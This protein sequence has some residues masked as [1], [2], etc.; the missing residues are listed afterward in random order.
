MEKTFNHP[1]SLD[2][3]IFEHRNKQ[4][5][6]YALRSGYNDRMLL[7]LGA[8]MSLI[9]LVA[10]IFMNQDN[11][12]AVTPAVV[13]EEGLVVRTIELPREKPL[14]PEKPKEAR[15]QKPVEKTATVKYI[16]SIKI[17]KEVKEEM[18]PVEE[19]GGKAIGDHNQDGKEADGKVVPSSGPREGGNGTGVA[20]P[21]QPDFTAVERGPEFP[22]GAVALKKFLARNLASP[23][24][25]ERG[26][27]KTVRI[28]F[29]VDTDGTVS[30]MEILSSGGEDFDD[31]VVRVCRRMPK[32][33]PALQNGV[34]VP[35]SYILP[36]TFM[37]SE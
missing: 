13:P 28:R 32:W 19:L 37:G 23:D 8:G 12:M 30:S 31:E 1:Q 4:Y 16:S 18:A 11:A 35:V 20:D 10:F 7:A 9:L 6:A 22:G 15:A 36:V 33:I 5:G 29:K 24:N 25:L 14:E 27:L 2:D 21:V 26:E 3:I 17:E 34:H